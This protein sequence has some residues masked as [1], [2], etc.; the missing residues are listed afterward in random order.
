MH[1]RVVN[2]VLFYP[3]QIC[4]C[5]VK[6]STISESDY[7]AIYVLLLYVYHMHDIYNQVGRGNIQHV[8]LSCTIN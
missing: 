3:L 6:L 1:V 8:Q 5:C 7:L 4:N 2:L